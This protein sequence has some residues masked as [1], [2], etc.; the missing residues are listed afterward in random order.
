MRRSR[1]ILAVQA[2]DHG[3]IEFKSGNYQ[4]A[5]AE[6]QQAL[7]YHSFVSNTIRQQMMVLDNQLS[8]DDQPLQDFQAYTAQIIDQNNLTEPYNSYHRLI[9]GMYLGGLAKTN[10][11]FLPLAEDNFAQAAAM[12]PGKA[13]TYM[14]WGEMY[15]K[16]NRYPE[17]EAKFNQA[18]Q[19]E[20]NHGYVNFLVSSWCVANGQVERGADL[21]MTALA[22]GYVGDIQT[23]QSMVGSLVLVGREDVVERFYQQI[24]ETRS[25]DTETLIWSIV[26][27]ALLYKQEGK[28]DQ[29]I[30][31]A[32][33]LYRYDISPS[34]LQ[35]FRTELNLEF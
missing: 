14:R 23:M 27:L 17:A 11:Q 15:A 24:I 22:A 4:L 35:K 31:A 8:S 33:Q 13:E 7:A 16:L 6:F 32:K 2:A 25:S 28:L 20:P 29:A 18:L 12:A 5:L 10:L 19:L 26:Q 9:S 30:A 21:I 3:T 1:P 34:E